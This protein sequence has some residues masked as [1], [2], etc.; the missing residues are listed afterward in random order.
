MIQTKRA[1]LILM[2]QKKEHVV[3][4]VDKRVNGNCGIGI[5]VYEVRIII[6]GAK[7]LESRMSKLE[8]RDRIKILIGSS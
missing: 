6:A 2:I 3:V 1:E 8:I 7:I 5:M 4:P